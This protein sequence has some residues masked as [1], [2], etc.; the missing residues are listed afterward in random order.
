[1]ASTSLH[2]MTKLSPHVFTYEP[3]ET[4]AAASTSGPKLILFAAWMEAA[5][6]H[7]SKY[8]AYYQTVYPDATIMLIKFVMREAMLAPVAT[9][10]VQP[11]VWHLRSMISAGALS[12]TP[13]RPEILVHLFSNGGAT[14]MQNVYSS[15]ADLF[16]QPF[17]LHCTVFDSCPGLHAFVKSYNALITSFPKGPLRF[18]MAPFVI[19]MILLAWLW[20]IP[21]G[22]IAGED[23]LTRNARVLND[24]KVVNQ[25]NRTYIYSPADTMVDWRH[26]EKHADRAASKG[27]NVRREIFYDSAHVT[28]MRADAKRYWSIVDE[29]WKKA[30][31]T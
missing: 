15:Y 11:A 30:V 6:L 16:G 26:I 8:I 10:A 24:P 31:S 18:L 1:M 21:F 2:M 13:E 23:F 28:H 22:F 19:L 3:S 14:T 27:F 5:D 4:R 7:I 17:P 9:N 29:T 12:A 20:H 25:T